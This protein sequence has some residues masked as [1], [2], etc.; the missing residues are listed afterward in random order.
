MAHSVDHRPGTVRRRSI[1]VRLAWTALTFGLAAFVVGA[2]R[3]ELPPPVSG[4]DAAVLRSAWALEN[5]GRWDD[6]IAQTGRLRDPVARKLVLWRAY[7]G[8][9]VPADFGE[10]ARF[11]E[12]NPDW[13]A[14][15]ALLAKAEQALY[16][17]RSYQ[18]VAGWL[19]RHPP[20]SGF[21]H[22]L[23]AEVL[24]AQGK[25]QQGIALIRKTWAEDDFPADSE[26]EIQARFS[27]YLR[28]AD[29]AARVDRL[30][31]DKKLPAAER[32]L[33]YLDP[34]HQALAQV[35]MAFIDQA[36]DAGQQLG[37]LPTSIR[38]DPGLL[39]DEIRWRRRTG[40]EDSAVD[41]MLTVDGAAMAGA[42][43]DRWWDERDALV[44]AALKDREYRKAYKLASGHGQ[45]YGSEFADGEWT[46]G[47]I[48]YRF[49]GD[50]RDGYM[51]FS[52]MYNGSG[53]PIS[54][55][56]GAY[57]AGRA[58][59]TLGRTADARNWFGEAARYSTTFYGQLG[60]E[61]LGWSAAPPLPFPPLPTATEK[62]QFLA[63]DSIRAARLAAD[64][65]DD[66]T[67]RLFASQFVK[68]AQDKSDWVLIG[69]FFGELRRPDLQV[70][71]GKQASY[72]KIVLPDVAYPRIY[73]PAGVPTEIAL[74]HG[75]SRQESAFNPRAVSVTGARG[76]MQLMPGTAEEV[77]RQ[78]G[79]PY[80]PPRL[81]SDPQYNVRLG[82]A[83]LRQLLDSF[84]GAYV[85][86]I[87]A[88]NAGSTRV[89]QWM[90]EYGDP[91]TGQIDMIDWIELIPFKE[92]RNYVERVL[93]NTQVYRQ[94]LGGRTAPLLIR[95]DIY[96]GAT[97]EPSFAA[98][99]RVPS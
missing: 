11:I 68:D 6:A 57:W 50:A 79:L 37:S 59:Q 12:A 48:A 64:L 81:T 45:K 13:P 20:V 4:A 87:A 75:V 61:A 30:L 8:R 76:L 82:S 24:M 58:A 94:I 40:M 10:L 26:P 41:L 60:A 93:E 32:M 53:K 34:A 83:Y 62:R 80:S 69:R 28:P 66:R 5:S 39:Y 19:R 92:T 99:P 55:G 25:M 51:H 89:S 46:A 85:L 23:Q 36:S 22:I 31:W 72:R 29:Y 38:R 98:R 2:A 17:Q 18:D 44:R 9:P 43:A 15:D 56:R 47:W 33:G 14:R 3:A 49:L 63:R 95:D 27:S 97:A 67:L 54:L 52:N 16:Q 91:R 84:N 70:W 88:Y 21:G 35:R 86:A 73:V 1:R 77:A 96:R 65:N 78:I 7:I 74:V 71:I 42:H 90:G